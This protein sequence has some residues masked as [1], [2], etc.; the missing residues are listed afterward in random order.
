MRK[1][2]F[3]IASFLAIALQAGAGHVHD[4]QQDRLPESLE[5]RPSVWDRSLAGTREYVGRI[6]AVDLSDF[7]NIHDGPAALADGVGDAF[8]LL[9]DMA[10]ETAADRELEK[11]KP[12][13]AGS[14]QA[15]KD[16]VVVISVIIDSGGYE[17]TMKTVRAVTFEGVGDTAVD[18]VLPKVLAEKRYGAW[19]QAPRTDLYRFDPELSYFL[20][21]KRSGDGYDIRKTP[22]TWLKTQIETAV[23]TADDQAAAPQQM[24][25]FGGVFQGEVSN[26]APVWGEVIF[27]NGWRYRGTFS[28]GV[29]CGR[30]TA[31]WRP[32]SPR[33]FGPS[34][35]I[36]G[37]FID[38]KPE[39]WCRCVNFGPFTV[40]QG[41][42]RGGIPNGFGAGVFSPDRPSPGTYFGDF[43]DGV[44]HGSG[45][46]RSD[47]GHVYR[48]DFREGAAHGSGS[49]TTSDGWKY[50]GQF[51][52][53][54]LHGHG[55][56]EFPNGIKYEGT[57]VSHS[58]AGQGT[59]TWG[60]GS[61]TGEFKDNLPTGNGTFRDA[62]GNEI[63]RGREPRT[64]RERGDFDR[65]RDRPEPKEKVKLEMGPGEYRFIERE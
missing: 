63:R 4:Q 49:L 61:Y 2:L 21:I 35:S 43:Q 47:A 40:F 36:N 45:L 20:T 7:R 18:A 22:Y 26:F 5:E 27:T 32:S 38:G 10:L 25:L 31:T 23:R 57:Y 13:I 44:P 59:L 15:A 6:R 39:G 29:L 46:W 54:M 19:I 34:V 48:G 12:L 65:I 17:R 14:L 9:Q 64:A 11:M 55:V 28:D 16:D 53:G 56:E 58:R 62:N 3:S 1:R 8:S 60:E 41:E 51:E 50:V 42:L 24:P 52:K 37:A 33:V 30:F